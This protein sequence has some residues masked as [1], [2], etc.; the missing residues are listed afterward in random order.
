MTSDEVVINGRILKWGNS[1]GVRI[2]KAE[3]RK[4]GLRPGADALVRLLK[5]PG[6]VDLSELPTFTGGEPEDSLRHDELLGRARRRALKER[7]G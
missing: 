7:P 5:R 2:R 4:A 3:L 6:T 1:Y